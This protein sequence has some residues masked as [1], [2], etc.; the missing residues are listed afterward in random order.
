LD[1]FGPSII[2]DAALIALEFLGVTPGWINFFR[3]FLQPKIRFS[4]GDQAEK[5][6]R[7]VPSSHALS[8]LFGETLLFLLDFLV[9]R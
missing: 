2:H 9:N 4:E 1:S 5:V 3:K 8:N 7:G 6:L